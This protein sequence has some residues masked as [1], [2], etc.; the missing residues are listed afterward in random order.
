MTDPTGRTGPHPDLRELIC[1]ALNGEG[2]VDPPGYRNQT[3]NPSPW[4]VRPVTLERLEVACQRTWHDIRSHST[5]FDGAS[6]SACQ[7]RIQNDPHPH[8]LFIEVMQRPG[9]VVWGISGL[10][11]G[12]RPPRPDGR[13]Y[14][15]G[16]TMVGWDHYLCTGGL[17]FAPEMHSLQVELADGSIFEDT[18]AGGCAILFASFQSDDAFA[19]MAAIRFLDA[20][21]NILVEDRLPVGG[22][23]PGLGRQPVP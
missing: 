7:V 11:G 22:D 21:G 23:P 13:P 4:L 17:G 9:E 12:E 8:S 3:D 5:L 14:H 1:D 16:G 6:F 20:D 10:S 19:D 18:F 15:E 2:Y